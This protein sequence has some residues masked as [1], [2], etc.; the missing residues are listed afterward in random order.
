MKMDL[1]LRINGK[2]SM[3][4]HTGYRFQLLC[5]PELRL[6]EE[7]T[8]ESWLWQLSKVYSTS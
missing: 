6:A 3:H 8:A 2:R 5:F 4:T 1:C 7:E